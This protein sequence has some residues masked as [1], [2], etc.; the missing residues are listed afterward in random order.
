MIH[1]WAPDAEIIAIDTVF[2]APVLADT[3]HTITGTVTD[4]DEEAGTVEIDIT[5]TNEAGENRVFGTATAKL[6]TR[7]AL[8]IGRVALQS[9]SDFA[10]C[11]LDGPSEGGRLAL[12]SAPRGALSYCSFPCRDLPAST[13]ACFIPCVATGNAPFGA[14]PALLLPLGGKAFCLPWRTSVRLS[15]LSAHGDAPIGA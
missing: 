1:R 2:R 5:I 9:P 6:P 14:G 12:P 13:H 10:A 7:R 8:G 15:S 4:I 11:Q 3:P